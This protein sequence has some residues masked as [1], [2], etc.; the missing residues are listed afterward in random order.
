MPSQSI[1]NPEIILATI[2]ASYQHCAFGLRYLLANM[3]ELK[4]RTK[5]MEF[6][7]HQNPRTI[8][9][10]ILALNPKIV[11]FGVYIWNAEETL[12]VI[13]ILKKVAPHLQI[14]LGGPEIS[15][16]TQQQRLL[17]YCD[18]VICG[19]ADF[20]FPELCRTLLI[21]NPAPLEQAKIIAQT[22]P[23]IQKIQLPYDLYTDEDIANRVIY[24]EASRGCPYKCEY[25]LSSLDKSVRSFDLNLFLSEMDLLIQ[26][27]ARQFKFVDRTF[28]LSI[29]TSTQIL[30][31]F[32]ERIDQGLFL[33]FEMVP[34]R[35]PDELKVLI[36]QFPTGSL[37]FE[38]GIQ[39]LN[40]VVAQNISRR[41]D[42]KKAQTNF[43]YLNIHHVHTH[44]DLIVG[45]PGETFDSFGEGF[46]RLLSWNPDEVQ[47][48]ILKRLKG[49]PIARHE[50]AFQMQYSDHQPYE[51]LSTKD[52]PFKQIQFMQKFA[53]FWDLYNNS[54]KFSA[55]IE[56]LFQNQPSRFRAFVHFVE[57]L[58]TLFSKTYAIHQDRLFEAIF[59]YLLHQQRPQEAVISAMGQDIARL[60]V[61]GHVPQFLKDYFVNY[62]DM[63]ELY[64]RRFTQ[65][66]DTSV[67]VHLQALPERQRQHLQHH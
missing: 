28:N 55:L 33:H 66:E 54:G 10:D 47:V 18:Y 19:E 24:V 40:P 44:A 8:C 53:K 22:I 20:A 23:D 38:I 50:K 12:H 48:G 67:A 7:I 4:T 58:E 42:L 61:R 51:I 1:Q 2:N 41:N 13:S 9:E 43:E 57:H 34:D 15:Y 46:D 56:I 49:T 52:M 30:R 14:I 17:K 64:L 37:Q 3:Q 26:R 27:G 6:T 39:T 32:L 29:Q 45:L 59:G 63:K 16:E 5:L 60:H 11:G 36:E 35:L 25:C 31:F 62:P 65:R 21:E